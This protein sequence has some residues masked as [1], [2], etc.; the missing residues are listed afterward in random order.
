MLFIKN[1]IFYKYDDLLN[2]YYKLQH[3]Y[4]IYDSENNIIYTY[5]FN[6]DD[7]YKNSNSILNTTEEFCVCFK[8]NYSKV[9]ITFIITKN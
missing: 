7:Y 5:L 1:N 9:T 2:N 3:K 6:K 4:N 8:K